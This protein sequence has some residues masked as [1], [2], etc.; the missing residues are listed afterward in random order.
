MADSKIEITVGPISFKGEGDGDWLANQLDKVLAKIPGLIAVAQQEGT[1]NG[2]TDVHDKTALRAKPSA[3]TDGGLTTSTAAT[4]LAATSGTEVSLAS[5]YVL[6]RKSNVSFTRGRLLQGMKSA[7][8]YFQ[9]NYRKNL[10]QSLDTLVKSGKFL[11]QGGENYAPS[12]ACQTE[13]GRKFG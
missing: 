4:K 7:T 8:S 12:V 3:G 5:A 9:V 2:G 10:G 13:L 11:H 6:H 1:V